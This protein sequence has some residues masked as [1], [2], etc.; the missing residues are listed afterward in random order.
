MI[1]LFP[2]AAT[3]ELSRF[4]LGSVLVA[5]ECKEIQ[6]QLQVLQVLQPELTHTLVEESKQLSLGALGPDYMRSKEPRVVWNQVQSSRS[7]GQL[8]FFFFVGGRKQ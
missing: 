1:D 6:Q 7:E 2:D 8:N 4:N 3:V 5:R